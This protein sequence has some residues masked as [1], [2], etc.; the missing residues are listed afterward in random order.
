MN[1]PVRAFRARGRRRRVFIASA[2]G[3]RITDDDGRTLPR[4]RRLLGADDPRPRATRRCVEA[5]R[6]QAADEARPSA[7]PP[8]ARDRA[9]RAR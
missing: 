2:A 9:G 3:A 4:L 6:E 1:S 5:I 8:R 7:R